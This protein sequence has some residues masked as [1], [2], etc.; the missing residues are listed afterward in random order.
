MSGTSFNVL[1][2]CSKF[3]FD[4][5]W[6]F[7]WQH[8]GGMMNSH[9]YDVITYSG[10]LAAC[11]VMFFI[12]K[13]IKFKWVNILLASFMSL[14]IYGVC[15]I[16]SERLRMN[17]IWS[18]IAFV[19]PMAYLTII[20]LLRREWIYRVIV[21]SSALF[22][23]A[24]NYIYCIIN[25]DHHKMCYTLKL[26]IL[27]FGIGGYVKNIVTDVKRKKMANTVTTIAAEKSEEINTE[28]IETIPE[29]IKNPETSENVPENTN[30]GEAE[31]S[32]DQE[33]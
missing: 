19:A 32:P 21:Y 1:Y 23:G 31:T 11:A 25:E 33:S 20:G 12:K 14:G 18:F 5:E 10:A 6:N 8:I 30:S 3:N 16:L 7:A 4:E 24:Y 17:S 28:K 27:A 2:F 29:A 26:F 13:H 9:F 15:A 22:I